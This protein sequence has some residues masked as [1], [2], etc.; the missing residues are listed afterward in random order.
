M[1]K[2][3]HDQLGEFSGLCTKSLSDDVELC[4]QVKNELLS[5]LEDAF[6][7]EQKSVPEKEAL[8]NAM[9][10]FGNPEEL[11]NLLAD[12]NAKRLSL[13]ARIRRAARW[14]F[15]PLLVFGVLLCI[16]I[17]GIM[18]STALMNS[19]RTKTW[20]NWDVGL[21]TRKLSEEEQLL[22][23]YHYGRGN[24][25]EI[26][27]SLY[28]KHSDD[29]MICAIFAQ[30][31][32]IAADR[33]PVV[34]QAKLSEVLANGSRIDP[35]NP[36]Y[37]Y[38][39]CLSLMR[40][41]LL[42]QTGEKSAIDDIN[43][44]GNLELALASISFDRVETIHDREKLDSAI[45]VYLQAQTKGQI[46]TYTSELLKSVQGMLKIK[47]DLLG[48]M[49]RIDA[50]SRERLLFRPAF[51]CIS[52]G[53]I[54]YCDLLHHEGDNA[55]AVKL[56]ATWRTYFTQYLGGENTHLVDLIGG[57]RL[58]GDYLECAKRLGASDEIAALTAIGEIRREMR[59]TIKDFQQFHLEGGILTWG[60]PPYP[61][62][63]DNIAEWS[64]ERRLETTTFATTYLG[65]ACFVLLIA[66]AVFG[67]HALAMRLLGRRPFLFILPKRIYIALLLTGIL[68]PSLLFLGIS[69]FIMAGNGRSGLGFVAN[70]L[71]PAIYLCALWP[72]CYGIYV[73]RTLKRWTYSI[74]GQNNNAFRASHSLNMLCCLAVL[75]LAIGCILRPIFAWSQGY[76]ASRE[77]LVIPREGVEI[78]EKRV[79]REWQSHLLEL[80]RSGAAPQNE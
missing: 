65:L 71:L 46:R 30:E 7:E 17:R 37:D 14:L 43:K 54:L 24:R 77:T 62:E 68:L 47:N 76:Y 74:G 20:F 73:H 8:Q 27:S 3:F 51:K 6:E 59:G 4:Q 33:Q 39:K 34:C 16:D 79:I 2:E 72:L 60:T 53:I 13:H 70:Q 58:A 15:L 66:I 64:V 32:S 49:H 10:R 1:N 41:A 35:T 45:G 36:L 75:L 80:C 38:L 40:E 21:R 11:S 44:R 25:L 19:V 12:S 26:L 5:H 56:L 63:G 67:L 9:R 61:T 57:I 55:R 52:K 50:A 29:P 48:G 78:R 28:E 22:F 18:S 69:H 31:L 42:P 23:D